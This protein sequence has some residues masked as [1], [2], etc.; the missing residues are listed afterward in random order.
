MDFER[1]NRGTVGK[2]ST[3]TARPRRTCVSRC[4][5]QVSKEYLPV[6]ILEKIGED[7]ADRD[8]LRILPQGE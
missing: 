7:P 5:E 8:R 4:E 6:P 1:T 3:V 2:I